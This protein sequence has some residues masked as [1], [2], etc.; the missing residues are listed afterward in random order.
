MANVC[1][2]Q[3]SGFVDPRSAIVDEEGLIAA[4]QV[5]GELQLAANTKFVIVQSTDAAHY[6]DIYAAT[7]ATVSA[8]GANG[9][10]RCNQ[11]DRIGFAV[12]SSQNDAGDRFIK[13]VA[14]SD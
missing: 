10:I 1:V 5:T 9:E 2:R 11:G 6:F 4:N 14:A 8:T 13:I 3:Y 12:K 7:G